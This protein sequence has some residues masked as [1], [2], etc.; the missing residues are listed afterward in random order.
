M[1]LSIAQQI[2][3]QKQHEEQRE[4]SELSKK[5]TQR[6]L[7][8]YD[9]AEKQQQQQ[10]QEGVNVRARRDTTSHSNTIES[11]RAPGTVKSKETEMKPVMIPM[12]NLGVTTRSMAAAA[13]VLPPLVRT[14]AQSPMLFRN[15]PRAPVFRDPANISAFNK[16]ES[17]STLGYSNFGDPFVAPEQRMNP[18]AIQRFNNTSTPLPDRRIGLQPALDISRVS[19]ASQRRPAPVV[20]VNESLPSLFRQNVRQ[21]LNPLEEEGGSAAAA[22]QRGHSVNSFRAGEGSGS[23]IPLLPLQQGDGEGNNTFDEILL[24]MPRQQRGFF[25]RHK[26]KLLTAGG[27]LAIGATIGGGIAGALNKKAMQANESNTNGTFSDLATS[28]GGGG[29][30]GGSGGAGGAFSSGTAYHKFSRPFAGYY[31]FRTAATA[32]Q[33]RRRRSAKRKT[34][35]KTSRR[36]NRNSSNSS[37]G[38][39]LTDGKSAAHKTQGRRRR[40]RRKAAV[41]GVV[42][43]VINKRRR[44]GGFTRKKVRFAKKILKRVIN[45]TLRKTKLRRRRR[46]TAF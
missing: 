11:S 20:E 25:Q 41:H 16:F 2:Q 46:S 36:R 14:P 31:P 39:Q 4:V 24:N 18:F 30:A 32:F 37:K 34:T 22:V 12:S 33:Q 35:R 17:M 44:L 3:L 23:R 42:K 19:R 9:E 26:R 15:T 40:R 1:G 7:N 13:N 43:K 6:Q 45:S 21:I 5:L 10:Q 38:R 29:G 28:G 27:I 8:L